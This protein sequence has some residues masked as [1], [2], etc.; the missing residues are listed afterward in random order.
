MCSSATSPEQ[1][2]VGLLALGAVS[3]DLPWSSTWSLVGGGA[4][5]VRAFGGAL[6]G[7]GTLGVP[8]Y[9]SDGPAANW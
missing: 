3:N 6:G 8:K 7:T 5:G 1:E 4:F 9:S 2:Y